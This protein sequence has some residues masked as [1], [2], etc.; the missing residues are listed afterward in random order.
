MVKK[1]IIDW[2]KYLI[3]SVFSMQNFE[4]SLKKTMKNTKKNTF[5]I[6]LHKALITWVTCSWKLWEHSVGANRLH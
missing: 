6:L 2:N 1:K 4:I 3:G 5:T